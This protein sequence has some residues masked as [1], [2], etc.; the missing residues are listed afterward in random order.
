M[1]TETQINALQET[2]RNYSQVW[3]AYLFG[4]Q[5]TGSLTP[6]SDV[7]IAVYFVEKFL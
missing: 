3:F 7:D 1:I 6:M 5:A 4:S 2:L